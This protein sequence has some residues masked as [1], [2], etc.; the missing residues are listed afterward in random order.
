MA[1][2]TGFFQLRRGLWEHVRDGRMSITEVLAFIYIGTQADTRTGI[3]KG[4]A[5]S[6]SG[7]LGIPERTARD[8]LEKM[9]HGNYIRRFAVPGR[10]GCYPILIHKFTVTNGEHSGEQLNALACTSSVD[11]AY[12]SR[13]QYGE[14]SVEHGVE[15][16]AAQK[17]SETE[18]WK[19][20]TKE[21]APAAPSL[22]FSGQ[23]FAVTQKQDALLGEAFPWIDRPAEYRKVDS[24]LEANPNRRPKRASRFLHNWFAKILAPSNGAKGPRPIQSS[25]PLA[26][27]QSKNELTAAGFRVLEGYG[28]VR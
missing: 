11:L 13:E 18:K 16:G 28:V 20:K 1:R 10:H 21:G 25:W 3:W 22:S 9:E 5:K 15:D 24:W 2:G 27:V 6:I 26:N 23:H 7:E 4:C 17:R 14:E 12:F 8:V 19:R